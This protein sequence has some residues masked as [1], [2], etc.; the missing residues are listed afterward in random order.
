[1]SSLQYSSLVAISRYY[2][3]Q[4]NNRPN[5]FRYLLEPPKDCEIA[6][7]HAVSLPCGFPSFYINILFIGFLLHLGYHPSLQK[8]NIN[9][10]CLL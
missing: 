5:N 7:F 3:Y 4:F 2:P 8:G 1:M 10:H 6:Q 9:L